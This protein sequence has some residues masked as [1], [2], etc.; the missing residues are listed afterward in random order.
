MATT[1]FR[2]IKYGLQSL[3][4]NPWLSVATILV[5]IFAIVVFE[6]LIIFNV[7]TDK[8][9][10]ALEDK[11]DISVYFKSTAPEDT[12]LSMERSLEAL[13]EVAS[14]EYISRDKALEIFKERNADDAIIVNALDELKDNP[15]LASLN[16][17]AHDPKDY[18]LIATYVSDERFAGDVE[19][20]TYTQSRAAIE[21]LTGI[22]DAAERTGFFLTLF[23]ACTAVL[24]TFNTVRLVIYSNK[25]EIGIM[26][27]VGGSN[28]FINGPYVI[29]GI[30]LGTLAALL[31]FLLLVP[32]IHFSSPHIQ[33][34]I[35]EVNLET[36]FYGSFMSLLGYQLLFGILLGMVSSIIAVR[37]Y[38]KT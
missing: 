37:R 21:R 16:I 23:L 22:V 25:E 2:I 11:I 24:V 14:V 33:S 35:P 31:S 9:I 18:S 34:F 36:Y 6:G 17:K 19:K 20:V 10:A 3:V 28:V 1:L 27:L 29:Q 8:T 12:I 30:L 13:A 26:R 38:F 5:M 4:R 7:L 32:V 15:L